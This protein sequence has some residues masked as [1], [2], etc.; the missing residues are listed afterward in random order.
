MGHANV[1]SVALPA[2]LRAGD[3][4]SPSQFSEGSLQK[5]QHS[6]LSSQMPINGHVSPSVSYFACFSFPVI[7]VYIRFS[8][9]YYY[10]ITITIQFILLP[11]WVYWPKF[12]CTVPWSC[13][14]FTT[15][16]SSPPTSKIWKH[17]TLR[18]RSHIPNIAWTDSSPYF[19]LL[20]NYTLF[21]HLRALVRFCS[22]FMSFMFVCYLSVYTESQKHPQFDSVFS[23]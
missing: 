13:P 4:S 3:S 5:A 7:M 22:K 17:S 2:V 16:H 12:C 8:W 19:S 11:A 6:K 14:L 20:Y 15:E 1:G 10:F 21:Y 18:V 9:V 23:R